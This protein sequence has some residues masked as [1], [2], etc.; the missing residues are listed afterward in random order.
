MT[1]LG[2]RGVP[3]DSSGYI[4]HLWISFVGGAELDQINSTAVYAYVAR[5]FAGKLNI[6]L[7]LL[8]CGAVGSLRAY[9]NSPKDYG[10]SV[11]SSVSRDK[12]RPRLSPVSP[13]E[14]GEK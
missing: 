9:Q 6:L 14:L 11:M 12:S 3:I 1:S 4:R 13:V 10:V 2:P 8:F 7:S 5:L